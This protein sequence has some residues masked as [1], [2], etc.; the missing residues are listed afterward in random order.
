VSN[1]YDDRLV[2]IDIVV[3]G[4]HGRRFEGH[5]TGRPRFVGAERVFT[6]ACVPLRGTARV[7]PTT[8]YRLWLWGIRACFVLD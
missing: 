4:P 3:R 7:A 1:R 6:A 8:T 2:R 5:F